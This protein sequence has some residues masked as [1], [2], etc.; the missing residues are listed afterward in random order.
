MTADEFYEL[1]QPSR[2]TLRMTHC[3]DTVICSAVFDSEEILKFLGRIRTSTIEI[4]K[5]K[6]E[7]SYFDINLNSNP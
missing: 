5:F 4:D 6:L 1:A 3:S 2:R 7:N